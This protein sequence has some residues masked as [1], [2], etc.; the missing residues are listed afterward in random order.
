MQGLIDNKFREERING[1][2]YLMS[3]PNKKHLRIQYN[4]CKAFNDYFMNKNKKC[5]AFIEDK[6]F[7]NK[8]NNF[9]P[10]VLV[11]CYDCCD[12]DEDFP[13]III[14]VLSNS[15]RKK[16]LY[17]KMKKYAELG[18]QEYWI[19]DYQS[20]VMDI[21][22]LEDGQYVFK[23]SCGFSDEADESENK[24]LVM[25]FSPV[26]FSD[27]IINANDIFYSVKKNY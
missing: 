15:T 14:E 8:E 13:L 22:M 24:E 5:E 16:D 4:I 18:V 1:I 19:V 26:L 27:M 10:D 21:Y 6:F 3:R 25:E 11:Y 9:I 17:V 12:N 2:I 20:S 23:F 7:V